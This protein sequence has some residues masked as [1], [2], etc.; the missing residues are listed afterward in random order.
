MQFPGVTTVTGGQSLSML[1]D[2]ATGYLLLSS[3]QTGN[4][5]ELFAVNP[6]D[7]QVSRIGHFGKE[8]YPAVSLYQYERITDLTLLLDCTAAHLY[9][10]ETLQL[11]GRIKPYTYRQEIT[12]SS[13]DPSVATVDQTGLVTAISGGTAIITATS[14]DAD[15]TGY[16]ASAHCTVSVDDLVPLRTQVQAQITTSDEVSQWVSLDTAS[17]AVTVNAT[18]DRR[19]SGGGAH[20]GKLYGMDGDYVANGRIY[21]IDGA[22]FVSTTGALINSNFAAL[23]GATF[24]ATTVTVGGETAQQTGYPIM[25]TKRMALLLLTDY[26]T[27]KFTGW[28]TLSSY[29]SD[30]GALAYM[31]ETTFQD[32]NDVTYPAQAYLA[33]GAGWYA[34]SLCHLF[35]R[36]C[37][38]RSH[39]DAGPRRVWQHRPQLRQQYQFDHDPGGRWRAGG[40]AHRLRRRRQGRAVLRGSEGGNP[41]LRQGRQCAQRR[42]TDDPVYGGRYC[43]VHPG[44]VSA[45]GLRRKSIV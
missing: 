34:V 5:G 45:G 44:S 1:Y 38:W 17:M 2:A 33:L 8:N 18:A 20:N 32:E 9:A 15:E 19:L 3:Y 36:H 23:D 13:S 42:Q 22:T 27:A 6:A 30:L 7:L 41:D 21:E 31:G 24:P 26:A 37:Q 16:H 43:P 40:P 28:Q 12:W 39:V 14:V 25:L 35:L 10:E 11:H 29:Y 4:Y